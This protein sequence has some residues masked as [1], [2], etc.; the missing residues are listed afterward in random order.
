MYAYLPL[1]A[2]LDLG[3]KTIWLYVAVAAVAYLAVDKSL[4]IK[5]YIDSVQYKANQAGGVAASI[6]FKLFDDLLHWAGAGNIKEVRRVVHELWTKYCQDERGPMRLAYDVFMAT[7]AK[8]RVDPEY[9]PAV[10]QEVVHEALGIDINDGSD[11]AIAKAAERAERLGW[12]KIGALG[13]AWAAR[14]WGAFSAALRALFAEFME[15]DGE[16]KIAARV[17]KPT[18]NAL[19]NDPR[20]KAEAVALVREFAKRADDDEA[21]GKA[22]I[23]EQAKAMIAAGEVT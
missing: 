7:W 21:A 22:A 11:M 6:G 2:K 4:A 18:L 23:R 15:A 17:A 10:V 16:L 9:G 14:K 5:H 13:E 3:D 8:L 1:L 12:S 20:Y 19:W